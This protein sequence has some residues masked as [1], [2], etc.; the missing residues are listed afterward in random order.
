[1]KSSHHASRPPWD[2]V[3]VH[4]LAAPVRTHSSHDNLILWYCKEQTVFYLGVVAAVIVL[5]ED[6]ETSM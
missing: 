2:L 1:M 5:V 4:G 3:V 6:I